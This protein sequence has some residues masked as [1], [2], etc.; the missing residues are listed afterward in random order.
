[1]NNLKEYTNK[2]TNNLTS[3]FSQSL[4]SNNISVKTP[5]DKLININMNNE[6]LNILDLNNNIEINKQEF[7][8]INNMS[9]SHSTK[10]FT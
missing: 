4:K 8:T 5:S 7:K 9:H 2:T 3:P 6:I 1:M 10:S